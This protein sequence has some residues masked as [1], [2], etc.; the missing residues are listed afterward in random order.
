MRHILRQLVHNNFG[1]A[2]PRAGT[3]MLTCSVTLASALWVSVSVPNLPLLHALDDRAGTSV[4]ISLQSALLG[5]DDRT[6]GG[7]DTQTLARTLGLSDGVARLLT[8]AALRDGVSRTALVPVTAQLDRSVAVEAAPAVQPPDVPRAIADTTSPSALFTAAAEQSNAPAGDAP[9]SGAPSA[10]TV[11]TPHPKSGP[12]AP[13]ATPPSTPPA[14]QQPSAPA[15][16]PA[17]PPAGVPPTAPADA[18][19]TAPPADI[20]SQEPAQ[21]PPVQSPPAAPARDTTPPV[22]HAHADLAAV[23]GGP[24]GATVSYAPPSATDAVDGAV[25]VTCLPA[26]GSVFAVGRTTVTCTASDAARNVSHSSFDVVVDDTTP[27]VIQAH[28]DLVAEADGPSGAA[29]SYTAPVATDAV[30][31]SVAV[32]CVPA[33]GSTLALGHTTVTC[34]AHDAA[35]NQAP[36][37]SFDVNVR[38]TT[39]PAIQVH[40]DLVVEATGASGASV[41]YS[42]PAASDL[43]DGSVAPAC[44]PASGTAFALGHTTVTCTAHDAVGNVAHSTFDVDVQ[45]TTAPLFQVP[46]DIAVPATSPS[47]AAVSFSVTATDAVDGADTVICSPASGTTF[48]VG[49]TTVT[50][51]AQD[52]AGNQAAGQSFSVFVTATQ[53]HSDEVHALLDVSDVL[54][55]LGLSNPV[56]HS[57]HGLVIDTATTAVHGDPV[58]TCQAFNAFTASAGAQLTAGQLASATPSIDVAR[59]TLGC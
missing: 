32:S 6:E 15:D 41:S 13:P 9:S 42:A 56:E 52:A 24:S 25:A 47:G 27:P 30:D 44:A 50:C 29:V 37:R 34:S 16:A 1:R 18:P 57:L 53:S 7:L 17:K 40:A 58:A 54:K 8:P 33:S 5:I 26:S 36:A 31:G 43:V 28:A 19:A 3:G 35:G 21:T 39:A 55:T 2:N 11:P 49:Q 45:D 46:A 4:A 20:P 22:I 10:P 48:A 12:T 38:D 59:T 23:A 14:K 51:S